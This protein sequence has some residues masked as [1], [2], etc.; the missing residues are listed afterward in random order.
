VTLTPTDR[1]RKQ[2]ILQAVSGRR[3]EDVIADRALRPKFEDEANSANPDKLVTHEMLA[4]MEAVR[5]AQ[6]AGP[7]LSLFSA[8][9]VLVVPGFLAS[10]L[11]DESVRRRRRGEGAAAPE[12]AAGAQRILWA[13][14]P[15]CSN[16]ASCRGPI[17]D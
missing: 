5:A 8:A 4:V 12:S 11:E 3:F 14:P 15:N 7:S 2:S 13:G 1:A 9:D 17:P 16:T 6:R 10:Q